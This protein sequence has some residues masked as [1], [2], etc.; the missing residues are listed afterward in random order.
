MPFFVVV[1]ILLM[2][3]GRQYDD[4]EAGGQEEWC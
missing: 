2:G 3:I 4:A 1:S